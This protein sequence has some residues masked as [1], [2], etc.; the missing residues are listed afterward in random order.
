MHLK[1]RAMMAVRHL[2]KL[3]YWNKNEAWCIINLIME[4]CCKKEH[5]IEHAGYPTVISH[6]Y[7]NVTCAKY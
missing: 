4:I 6:M 5:L 3:K 1:H 2:L 7:H